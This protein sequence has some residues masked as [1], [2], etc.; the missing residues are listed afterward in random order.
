MIKKSII[1]WCQHS[2]LC[3]M[4]ISSSTFNIQHL[5]FECS[6]KNWMLHH[7]NPRY[8]SHKVTPSPQTI[9]PHGLSN[10]SMAHQLLSLHSRV[11]STQYINP[12]CPT[13]KNIIIIIIIIIKPGCLWMPMDHPPLGA[14][15]GPP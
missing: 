14:P 7:Y 5:K 11:D 12:T 2:R 4:N 3:S 6:P 1:K 9:K 8:Q 15:R 10:T 13:F